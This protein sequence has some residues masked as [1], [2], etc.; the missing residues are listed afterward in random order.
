MQTYSSSKYFNPFCEIIYLEHTL[1]LN[2]RGAYLICINVNVYSFRIC[3]QLLKC[4]AKGLY[5]LCSMN[6]SIDTMVIIMKIF[7]MH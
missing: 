7:C 3:C 2:A 1:K 4:D 6:I 5:T